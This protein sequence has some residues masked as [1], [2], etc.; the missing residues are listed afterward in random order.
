MTATPIGQ[1]AVSFGY[2]G[3]ARM[4]TGLVYAPFI[5]ITL[6]CTYMGDKE[7]DVTEKVNKLEQGIKETKIGLYVLSCMAIT[8]ITQLP[9]KDQLADIVAF[10]RSNRNLHILHNYGGKTH[11][12]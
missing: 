7:E 6:S 1:N 2:K 10:P 5:P 11:P 9:K 12:L 3:H 8:L 4:S